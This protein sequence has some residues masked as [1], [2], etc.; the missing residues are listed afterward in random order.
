MAVQKKF[1]AQDFNA[2]A[3]LSRASVAPTLSNWACR[4]AQVRIRDDRCILLR[5]TISRSHATFVILW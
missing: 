5:S 4:L 3:G 1:D 2:V